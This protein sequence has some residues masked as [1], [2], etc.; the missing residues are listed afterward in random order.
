MC[1]VISNNSLKVLSFH[2]RQVCCI[3]YP[4]E[5]TCAQ[6]IHGPWP[7]LRS[8]DGQQTLLLSKR[9]QTLGKRLVCLTLLLYNRPT[10]I[11]CMLLPPLGGQH[12]SR[13]PCPQLL[14]SLL[15]IEALVRYQIREKT[16]LIGMGIAYS[17]EMHIFQAS[18]L[19]LLHKF[20]QER[21]KHHIEG[22][23]FVFF[24]KAGKEAIV[25]LG[26][27]NLYR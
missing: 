19:V 11:E 2:Q 6:Q 15:P 17:D 23:C 12:K 22:T 8:E 3:N 21:R 20:S 26:R 10:G 14:L 5:S 4:G 24:S 1:E 16:G 18:Q 7:K 9:F 13:S 25:K 27:D